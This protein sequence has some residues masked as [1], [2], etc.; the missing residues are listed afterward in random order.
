MACKPGSVLAH[1]RD[2]H[3]SGTFVAERLTRPTRTAAGNRHC[4]PYLVL[5]PVGLAVPPSLPKAR[6]A[7]TAPFQPCPASKSDRRFAFCC[8]FPG[9]AS[10]GRYPAPCFRGA[11]TFLSPS[12]N[13][14]RRAAIR[15]SDVSGCGSGT[16]GM[17]ISRSS[18][19]RMASHSASARP[20]IF[21]GRKWRW[22]ASITMFDAAHRHRG[23][24]HSQRRAGLLQ[25]EHRAR[26]SASAATGPTPASAS[27][28]QGKS[29]PGSI[30]R[31]GATSE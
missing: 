21:A 12:R 19:A 16:R 26:I 30:L 5:L 29:S 17:S 27:L 31:A 9:V 28:P 4:R 6:C 1:A 22:N 7:L 18:A 23:A 13:A 11:R 14:L 25:T 20:S 15:P 24:I 8:A 3:S 10:A 2:G